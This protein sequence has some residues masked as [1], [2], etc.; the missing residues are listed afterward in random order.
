[1]Q[2]NQRA[3]EEC[4]EDEFGRLSRPLDDH[5]Q[6]GALAGEG[7]AV[8]GEGAAVAG[9]GTGEIS[10]RRLKHYQPPF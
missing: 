8:A 9:E 7:S 5:G 4:F 3:L 2:R 6:A 1:M 10:C